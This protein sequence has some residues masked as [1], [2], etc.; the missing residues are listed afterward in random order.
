MYKSDQ[1][2]RQAPALPYRRGGGMGGGSGG[3]SATVPLAILAL[4]ARDRTIIRIDWAYTCK[5]SRLRRPLTTK[6]AGSRP[7]CAPTPRP[8]MPTE[9]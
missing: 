3:R 8:R 4:S 6:A 7:V 2:V 9:C 1:G 5:L